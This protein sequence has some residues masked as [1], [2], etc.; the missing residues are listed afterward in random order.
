MIQPGQISIRTGT[1]TAIMTTASYRYQQLAVLMI[2]SPLAAN[3]RA[4]FFLYVTKT[5]GYKNELKGFSIRLGNPITRSQVAELM[6]APLI[7]PRR[8]HILVNG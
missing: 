8:R 7:K 1:T 5:D 3:A 6:I 2:W 4:F